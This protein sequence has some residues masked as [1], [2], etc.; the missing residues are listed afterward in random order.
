MTTF[1]TGVPGGAKSYF[2]IFEIS[3]FFSI[4]LKDNK[5][6]KSHISK[7][8]PYKACLTNINEIKLDKFENVSLFDFQKFYVILTV[9]HSMFKSGKNDTELLQ[10]LED[11]NIVFADTLIVVDECQNFLEK[12]DTILVWWLSYHRHFHQDIILITQNLDL[13]NK[14]YFAFS[15]IYL[16]AIPSSKKISN[17]QMIYQQFTSPKLYKNSQAN[18]IKLPVVAELFTYYKSGANQQSKS[19]ILHYI[20]ISIFIFVTLMILFFLFIKSKSPDKEYTETNT[21]HEQP[22]Q[23]TPI[24][25]TK[26]FFDNADLKLFVFNCFD[27]YCYFD[28]SSKIPKT[29]FEAVIQQI[30]TKLISKREYNNSTDFYI[31]T[32]KNNFEFIKKENED[33]KTSI[34]NPIFK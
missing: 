25:K 12:D 16:K 31:I 5:K 21:Y 14:K 19:F 1:L 23:K 24:L 28:S 33:E 30:E 9:L 17:N 10:Y 8:N 15:E 3:K 11:N 27:D 34:S 18:T 6:F 32:N 22:K 26:S 20:K 13:V 2:G 29:L 4:F 7:S